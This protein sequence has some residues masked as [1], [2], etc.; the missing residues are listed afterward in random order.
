LI[1]ETLHPDN[2]IAKLYSSNASEAYKQNLILVMNDTL[3]RRDEAA[4]K[5][6]VSRLQL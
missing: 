1:C 4:Y 2:I 3:T 6:I 5:N